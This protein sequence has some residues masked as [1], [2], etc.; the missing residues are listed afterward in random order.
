VLQSIGYTVLEAAD[1]V[2]G[3]ALYEKNADQID[4][5]LTDVVMP[6]IN[7][8]ELAE[9]LGAKRRPPE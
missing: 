6:R 9:R 1:G 7:G 4:L 3:L 8:F 5:L 2:A